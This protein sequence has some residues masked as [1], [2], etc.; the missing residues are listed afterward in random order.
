MDYSILEKPS[1][2]E[3]SQH[4]NWHPLAYDDQTE[5]SFMDLAEKEQAL[6]AALPE[7]FVIGTALRLARGPAM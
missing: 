7:D 4:L 1:W 5:D 2:P 3:L 6:V